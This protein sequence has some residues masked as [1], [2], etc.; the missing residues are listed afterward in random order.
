MRKA[1]DTPDALSIAIAIANDARRRH[2]LRQTVRGIAPIVA[3]AIGIVLCVATIAVL[4]AAPAAI[5]LACN[6][7]DT[8]PG[9]L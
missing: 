2:S 5:P 6:V 4:A 3:L 7:L 1:K 9:A 8:C